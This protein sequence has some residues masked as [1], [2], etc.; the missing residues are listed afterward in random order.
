[1]GKLMKGSVKK[2]RDDDDADE[3]WEGGGDRR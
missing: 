2:G 1:M 3:N